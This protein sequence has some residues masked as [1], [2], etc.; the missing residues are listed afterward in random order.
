[1]VHHQIDLENSNHNLE[2]IVTNLTIIQDLHIIQDII[3]HKSLKLVTRYM[4]PI[5]I[6][7]IN[8]YPSHIT[9]KCEL[10]T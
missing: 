10:Y 9:T 1:M 7:A 5:P 2:K 4:K 3:P 8:N 6:S